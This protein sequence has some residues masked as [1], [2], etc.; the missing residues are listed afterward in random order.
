MYV[1][2]CVYAFIGKSI[3]FTLVSDPTAL[4]VSL[5]LDV[6]LAFNKLNTFGVVFKTSAFLILYFSCRSNYLGLS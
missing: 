6:H 4:S 2:T 5:S 3:Q 1:L